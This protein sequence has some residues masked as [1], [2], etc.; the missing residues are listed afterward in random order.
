VLWAPQSVESDF[1]IGYGLPTADGAILV[2]Q[3][4][5]EFLHEIPL[6]SAPSSMNL[7]KLH[8]GFDV[9]PLEEVL[10]DS[11]S[12]IQSES[13]TESETEE[14]E[15]EEMDVED[16]SEEERWSGQETRSESV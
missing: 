4:S 12:E 2:R 16:L 7:Y 14:E 13:D 8:S 6:R 10:F 1:C 11:D 5:T 3:I 15:E 9:D